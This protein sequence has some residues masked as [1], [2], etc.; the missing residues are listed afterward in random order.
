MN[1]CFLCGDLSRSGGTEKITK[2]ITDGIISKN[3]HTVFIVDVV[4][5]K[6][7]LYYHFDEKV[8]IK[9]LKQGN[10]L[11]KMNE[12]Y[13][14]LKQFSIDIIINV[15]IMLIIYSYLPAKMSKT[16]IISWEQFNFYNDIGSSH[17]K[18]IRQFCLKHTDY[19]V[20]LTKADME[21]FIKNFKVKVP[22]TYIYNPVIGEKNSSYDLNSKSIITA[23]NFYAAKGYDY[24]IKVGEIVFSRHP[25]WVWIFCGD[26]IEFERIKKVATQSK[27]PNNFIFAGRVANLQDYMQDA[28]MY[29]SCSLTEGFGLVLI[30]AQQC[31]LPVVAFDVPFGPSEIISDNING[32]LINNLDVEIM[33]KEIIRLIENV[34]LREMFSE[35]SDISHE[36]FSMD[37]VLIQWNRI[38]NEVKT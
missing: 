32:C 31:G 30:E 15:D 7:E 28:A 17:T 9:H 20:N 33:A 37:S 38:F 2:L 22:I 21:T 12:L 3:E 18:S 8:T 29:V 6:K 11:M 36:K 1:I 24:C 26:G 16:K 25:E 34:K 27:F 35:K 14:I 13:H 10:M 19:Y 5:V 4:N 23:G